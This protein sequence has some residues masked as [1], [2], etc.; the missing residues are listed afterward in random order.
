M[1]EKPFQSALTEADRCVK[2]GLCLPE[3][4]TYRLYSDENE[5]PRGRIALA[6][7]LL[8]GNIRLNNRLKEHFDHCLLCR[9]CERVCPSQ[10]NYAHLMDT[11]RSQY[12]KPKWQTRLSQKPDLAYQ[13]LKIARKLPN[14]LN[15]DTIRLSKAL[16]PPIAAPKHGTYPSI[17]S[18]KG[19]V[20]LFLGCITKTAQASA[21]HAAIKVLTL[22][23]FD[24]VISQ[25]QKC[26]GA[27]DAHG[28]RP[29]LAQQYAETN[30]KAFNS[31]LTAIVGLASGCTVQLSEQTPKLQAPVQDIS[32]FL[33]QHADWS[34]LKIKPLLA[35]CALH[36]PCSLENILL[37]SNAVEKI[38][39]QIP[40]LSFQPL[41]ER[42]DCCGAAGEHLL[43]QQAQAKKLRA[44][45]LAQLLELKPGYLLTSN[46][47]CALHLAEGAA[48]AGL[49]IETL[50]PIEL[51]ARQ[52]D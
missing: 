21:L 48:S 7:G 43:S 42:G 27:L 15:P 23:G 13:L 45:L 12:A 49:T 41:G 47:G 36:Q 24:V 31:D 50:H 10:V 5:S 6:E 11:V 26:C 39:K 32:Q 38:L 3:C 30:H 4:P 35:S 8:K 17:G 20:G 16:A 18:R 33:N 1:S 40:Q 19:S 44:P 46:I 34:Q 14:W 28:G 52:L 9:R 37:S 2:C 29:Q 51:L 22:I 25:R